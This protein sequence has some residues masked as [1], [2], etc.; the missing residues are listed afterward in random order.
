MYVGAGGCE[1]ALALIYP[2]V[3]HNEGRFCEVTF[4]PLDERSVHCVAINSD[5]EKNKRKK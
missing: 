2:T 1:S 4:S 5:V 3:E